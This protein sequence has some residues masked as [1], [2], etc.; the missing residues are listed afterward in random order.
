MLAKSHATTRAKA[1][2]IL[3]DKNF[4]NAV[5]SYITFNLKYSTLI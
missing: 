3:G 5:S 4:S 1:P 2:R